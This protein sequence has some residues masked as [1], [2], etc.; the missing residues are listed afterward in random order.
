LTIE[1]H[2]TCDL[3]RKSLSMINKISAVLNHIL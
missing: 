2:G 3:S 1:V